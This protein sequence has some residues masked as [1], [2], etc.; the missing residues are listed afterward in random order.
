MFRPGLTGVLTKYICCG[1]GGARGG[2]GG[3]LP[4]KVGSM[5]LVKGVAVLVI[6]VAGARVDMDTLL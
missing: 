5:L 1:P 4:K 2:G 3:A 6:K